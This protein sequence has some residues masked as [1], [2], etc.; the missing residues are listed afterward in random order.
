MAKSLRHKK[1]RVGAP[2]S[3]G[4]QSRCLWKRGDSSKRGKIRIS[5][6]GKKM[7]PVIEPADQSKKEGVASPDRHSI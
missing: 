1:S 6:G 3:S 5:G 2:K 7:A 4:R